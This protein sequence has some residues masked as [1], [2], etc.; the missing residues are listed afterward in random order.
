MDKKIMIKLFKNW[1]LQKKYNFLDIRK[2]EDF[3]WLLWPILES[4]WIKAEYKTDW[5]N[6]DWIFFDSKI[7]YQARYFLW[8][9]LESY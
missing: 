5:F 6:V 7:L 8:I 3:E 2:V 4:N 9:T 1:I